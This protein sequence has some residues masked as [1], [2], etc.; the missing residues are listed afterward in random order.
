MLQ[1]KATL[2]ICTLLLEKFRMKV[3]PLNPETVYIFFF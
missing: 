2:L 3:L 1:A